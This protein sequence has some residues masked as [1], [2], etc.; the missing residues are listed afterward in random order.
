MRIGVLGTG[1]VGRTL[2]SALVALGHEVR[3]GSRSAGNENAVAWVEEAGDGASEADFTGA[4]EFGELLVNATGGAV[5]VQ[6]LE[7]AGA[8]HLSGKVLLDVSNPLDFSKGMPPTL[9]VCNDDS[10]G[11]QIQA[12]F[13]DARVV[14]TLNTVTTSVMVEPSLVPGTHTMFV[15]G[16]DDDAKAQAREI[17]EAFGW[18]SASI[19]DLGDITSSR[20]LEM[21]L[22]L[23][24]RLWGA[25]GSGVLNIEVRTAPAPE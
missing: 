23:W 4:A 9:T 14:K 6:A 16:N 22:P 7:Q 24:L 1:V 21:Y 2:G 10:V 13:P 25:T 15:C 11:E 19:L 12:A 18:P 17:L 5:S 20:G 3:M 8:E